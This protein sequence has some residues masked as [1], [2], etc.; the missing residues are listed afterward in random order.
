[1]KSHYVS[2]WALVVVL[3]FASNCKLVGGIQSYGTNK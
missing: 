1:M 3:L 2:S